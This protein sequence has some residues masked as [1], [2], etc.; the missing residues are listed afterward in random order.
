MKNLVVFSDILWLPCGVAWLLFPW[1][2]HQ[3]QSLLKLP[4]ASQVPQPFQALDREVTAQTRV[5]ALWYVSHSYI[6]AVNICPLVLFAEEHER[7]QG[8]EGRRDAVAFGDDS[9]RGCV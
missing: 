8:P 4:G 7:I 3:A 1:S 9:S 6:Y 5:V 2:D